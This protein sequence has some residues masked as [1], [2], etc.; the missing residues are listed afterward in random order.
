MIRFDM[1]GMGQ[2]SVPD[3]GY[4]WSVDNFAADLLD[5]MDKLE[6]EKVH[7]VKQGTSDILFRKSYNTSWEI[8]KAKAEELINGLQ[9]G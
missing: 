4:S 6:L 1:R 7:L 9:E 5:F 3:P 8:L 2:S